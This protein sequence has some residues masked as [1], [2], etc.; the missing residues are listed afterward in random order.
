MKGDTKLYVP[1]MDF[2]LKPWLFS[3]IS[4]SYRVGCVL[5][6][7][8]ISLIVELTVLWHTCRIILEANNIVSFWRQYCDWTMMVVHTYLPLHYSEMSFPR[9][10][11]PWSTRQSAWRTQHSPN[12]SWILELLGPCILQFPPKAKT[13][14][15]A[16]HWIPGT[17]L[18]SQ[19]ELILKKH[20]SVLNSKTCTERYST[21]GYL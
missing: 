18:F 21:Y 17:Y 7:I 3:L 12:S 10:P 6:D 13:D 19:H 16:Y 14:I 11:E 20:N 2:T 1:N 5:P 8:K 4:N 15:E 9:A